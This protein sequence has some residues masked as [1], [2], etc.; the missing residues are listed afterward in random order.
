M[1][2]GSAREEKR[3]WEDC[4][5]AL[6]LLLHLLLLLSPFRSTFTKHTLARV[7]AG[8]PLP[9]AAFSPCATGDSLQRTQRQGVERQRQRRRMRR[10]RRMFAMKK[11]ESVSLSTYGAAYL[12]LETGV[13]LPKETKHE[14][15]R[16]SA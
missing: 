7:L 3:D 16:K 8:G 14:T 6:S 5:D 12:R 4:A 2:S 13:T 9:L 10:R 11:I 15:Q 1:Q